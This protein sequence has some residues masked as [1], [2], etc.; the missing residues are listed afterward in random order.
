RKRAEKEIRRY[1]ESLED[2]VRERTGELEKE[3]ER[4]EVANQAKSEFLANMSHELRTPLNHILGFTELVADQ[5]VGELNEIQEDYLGDALSSGRHLLS[6]I[7]DILDLSKV[8]AGKLELEMV[9]VDPR[10]LLENSLVMVKEKAIRRGIRLSTE[11]E[12]LPDAIVGD[13]R[14]L[15]QILYNLLSNAVKFTPD[16]G[17]V[18]LASRSVEADEL[19]AMNSRLFEARPLEMDAGRHL[20]ISV[21]DD[22]VG[23][24]PEDLDRVFRPFEQGETSK[25]RRFQGTGLGLSLTRRLVELHGGR[26]WAE[27]EGKGQGSVFR[28]VIPL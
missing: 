1:Q 14:A 2:L 15:K 3:K 17:R 5:K 20:E 7:N 24:K 11:L 28:V 10:E 25:S 4:A 8:E 12:A 6:L 22:G 9:R 23:V 21:I 18:R 19:S 13:R 26:I 16:G 27:S